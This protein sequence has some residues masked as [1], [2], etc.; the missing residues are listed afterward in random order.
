MIAGGVLHSLKESQV[1]QFF[2][3]LADNFSDGEIVFDA[4]SRSD[5]GSR[6]WIDMFPPEQQ[7]AM[8]GSMGGGVEGLVGERVE[9]LVGGGAT[10]PERQGE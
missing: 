4:M 9:R 6:T 1:R 7:D 2:S 5:G 8:R 3:M 10:E